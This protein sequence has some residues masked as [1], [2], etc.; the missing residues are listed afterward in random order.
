MGFRWLD[1]LRSSQPGRSTRCYTG[2]FRS[3]KGITVLCMMPVKKNDEYQ[4]NETFYLEA[5]GDLFEI[6]NK[7]DLGCHFGGY[8]EGV[9]TFI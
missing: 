1:S 3:G 2:N 4:I 6:K 9:V 7:K 8:G 5:D